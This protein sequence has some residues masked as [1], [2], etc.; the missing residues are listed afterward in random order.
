[1][2]LFRAANSFW[3]VRGVRERRG[4]ERGLRGHIKLPTKGTWHIVCD[5]YC[6]CLWQTKVAPGQW[7]AAGPGGP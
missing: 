3:K 7:A 2:G 5:H 4:I 1:M 6:Q